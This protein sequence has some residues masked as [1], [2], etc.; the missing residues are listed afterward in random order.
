MRMDTGQT[1]VLTTINSEQFAEILH[2]T[3][4]TF[5]NRRSTAPESLPPPLDL[6]GK[7]PLW[8]YEDVLNWLRSR[9]PSHV[10]VPPPKKRGRPRN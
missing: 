9:R 2:I 1:P 7:Q 6:P 10:D 3:V 5:Y 8:L 4:E